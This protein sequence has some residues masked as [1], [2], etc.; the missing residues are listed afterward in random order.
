MDKSRGIATIEVSFTTQGRMVPFPHIA[1]R[2]GRT[3]PW[4]V[5]TVAVLL[6]I[7]SVPLDRVTEALG[8]IGVGP[9]LLAMVV[10]ALDGILVDSDR[11]KRVCRHLGLDLTLRD[12]AALAVPATALGVVAPLQSDEVL[13]ARQLSVRYGRPFAEALG[14]VVTDR[15]FSLVAH[16][17]L[18]AG[19]LAGLLSGAGPL[20]TVA[21]VAT[22]TVACGTFLLALARAIASWPRLANHR[23]VGL[24]LG[25]FRALGPW[26]VA[27]M[28]AYAL[29]A[30]LALAVTLAVMAA[31]AGIEASFAAILVWRHGSILF[32][33]IPVTVGGY[34][35]REGAL[36]LGLSAYGEAPVA[37]AVAV[38]L[39]FGACAS[40]VPS[41]V[42]LAFRPFVAGALDCLKQDLTRGVREVSALLDPRNGRGSG[43]GAHDDVS[44]PH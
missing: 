29:A 35:L 38:A 2:V 11:L 8:W 26:F 30:D 18:L 32:G 41:L 9:T 13:K 7:V 3:W 5:T 28:F 39:W 15:G 4:A 20:G 33:K 31:A 23:V 24:F 27:G 36:A 42:A 1:S 25:P 17:A 19:G 12:A 14:I 22:G 43:P 10:A 34:G 40:L 37:V 21:V 6:V 16:A 44:R